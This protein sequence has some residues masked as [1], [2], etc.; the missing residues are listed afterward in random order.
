[1][2]L[3]VKMK[4]LVTQLGFVLVSGKSPLESSVTVVT[5]SLMI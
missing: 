4:G 5:G 2:E 3:N 1:M